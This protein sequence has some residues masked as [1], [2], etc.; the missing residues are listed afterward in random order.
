MKKVSQE[1]IDFYTE[2]LQ[3]IAQHY[4]EPSPKAGKNFYCC[5]SCGSGMGGGTG[6]LHISEGK[7][8]KAPFFN[9]YSC[10][11]HGRAIDLVKLAEHTDFRGAIESLRHTFGHQFSDVETYDYH[12]KEALLKQRE[13]RRKEREKQQDAL[14]EKQKQDFSK[15]YWGGQQNLIR[16][17]WKEIRGIPTEFCLKYGV[18]Y[19]A[20]WRPPHI[21]GKVD[22]K[23]NPS[24]R[25][26]LPYDANNYMARGVNDSVYLKKYKVKTGKAIPPFLYDH[27]KKEE[28][29]AVFVVEGE[30]D[31]LSIAYAGGHAVSV[32]S[33]AMATSFG[34]RL[35]KD[36][37]PAVV[38]V[39]LDDDKT[40]NMYKTKMIE[41]LKRLHLPYIEGNVNGEYKDPNEFL[42]GDK[43]GFFKAVHENIEKAVTLF[44]QPVKTGSLKK[45]NT[46]NAR[47]ESHERN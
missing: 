39:S 20:R 21:E 7:G 11:E 34:E 6:A 8:G 28:P 17:G 42:Q 44:R 38:I 1:E 41:T 19:Y 45:E 32:G 15:F 30:F 27:M 5:P 31:A 37:I 14:I 9:C 40:G 2:N 3:E 16:T 35:A 23:L 46:G 24:P 26:I 22:S 4:L 29:K 10:Q 25:F 13:L 43:E 18:G 12:D 33:A 36:K 47:T